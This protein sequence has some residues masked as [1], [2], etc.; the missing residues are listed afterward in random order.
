MIT[1]MDMNEYKRN[2]Y[3][4]KR[5]RKERIAWEFEWC[6]PHCV[7]MKPAWK[8]YRKTLFDWFNIA[9][10]LLEFLSCDTLAFNEH[11]FLSLRARHMLKISSHQ[12]GIY[13]KKLK[14]IKT[15]KIETFTGVNIPNSLTKKLV[16]DYNFIQCAD[17]SKAKQKWY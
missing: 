5:A 6:V 11:T 7:V 2:T 10:F 8:W 9:L 13:S 14:T 17:Q 4:H 12:Y 1:K 15:S 16:I 3:A